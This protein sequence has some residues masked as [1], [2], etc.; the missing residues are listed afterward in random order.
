M[1]K[2]SKI[3]YARIPRDGKLCEFCLMLASRGFVYRSAKTAGGNGNHYHPNCRCTVIPGTKYTEI[4]GYDP[5]KL[6]MKWKNIVG[7]PVVKTVIEAEEIAIPAIAEAKMMK[8]TLLSGEASTIFDNVFNECYEKLISG[9]MT[10][11]EFKE[12][13]RIAYEKYLKSKKTL[14][15]Y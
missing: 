4:A 5:D 1:A 11:V 6:Y 8:E 13:F 14:T 10:I 15:K 2:R 7:V 3:R 12:Q 9:T